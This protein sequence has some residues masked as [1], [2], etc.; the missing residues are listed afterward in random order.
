MAQK[1]GAVDVVIMRQRPQHMT[2]WPFMQTVKVKQGRGMAV[3]GDHRP[4]AVIL[5]VQQ[6]IKISPGSQDVL[7]RTRG[8]IRLGMPF[9][10][11]LPRAGAVCGRLPI[12]QAPR[13]LVT[14]IP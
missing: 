4:A 3:I 2:R 12:V 8:L 13:R 14:M 10:V 1:F 9:M 5:H 11:N 6:E 7:Q